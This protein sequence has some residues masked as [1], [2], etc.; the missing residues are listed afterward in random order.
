MDNFSKLQIGIYNAVR[1]YT[2]TSLERVAALVN[3]I[4]YIVKKNIRGDFVEC[5]VWRGGSSMAMAL[6]LRELG[7]SDRKIYLFDTYE[8]MSEPT[9]IDERNSDGESAITLLKK[10]KDSKETDCV[11][12]Y[13]SLQ[14]VEMNMRKTGY[15]QD[16]IFFIKG[17]VEDTL[18]NNI[19]EIALL[20]LDTDWYKSTLHELECLYPSL[21]SRGVL[22]V[23][24]YGYWRGS[25]QA[26]DEYFDKSESILL[27]RIDDTG[28]IGV[29]I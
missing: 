25:K 21:V 18:P 14:E 13:S 29:K 6:T 3:A 17:R 19:T 28:I 8:G 16:N 20:R 9:E 26:V 2:M 22:I 10:T 7:V 5:G 11:W 27:N 12:A 15:S 23:D 1:P 24:D 4:E